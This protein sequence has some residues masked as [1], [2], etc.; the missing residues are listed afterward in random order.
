M[1]SLS[2]KR[3]QVYPYLPIRIIRQIENSVGETELKSYE[4][5]KGTIVFA[6]VAGF[7]PMS[8][9]IAKKGQIGNEEL[10]GI[11]TGY[12]SALISE[13]RKYSGSVYQFAGDSVLIAF[14][15]LPGEHE[16]ENILRTVKCVTKIQKNIKVFQEVKILEETYNILAKIGV[17]YG[18]Y[19]QLILGNKNHFFRSV[20]SGPAVESAVIAQTL[21]KGGD[22]VICNRI[23]GSLEQDL[24]QS[25]NDSFS[26]LSSEIEPAFELS[27]QEEQ[28]PDLTLE[29]F[30]RIERFVDP[31]LRQKVIQVIDGFQYDHR[32][33]TSVLIRVDANRDENQ[34]SELIQE[35]NLIYNHILNE[36]RIFGGFVIQVDFTDKGNVFFVLFNAPVA[37][38]NKEVSA[39]KMA[40]RLLQMIKEATSRSLIFR[41][42]IGI[43]TGLAFCGDL[44]APFRKG[45]TVIGEDVNLA[46]RLMHISNDWDIHVDGLTGERIKNDFL[47]EQLEDQTLKGFD[48]PVRVF[49]V[50]N[51]V[52]RLDG[53]L[54]QYTNEFVGRKVEIEKLVN[55]IERMKSNYGQICSVVGENGI[56]KS[57]LLSMVMDAPVM[58]GVDSYPGFCTPQQRHTPYYPWK[59]IL[60]LLLGV[61]DYQEE[62]FRINRIREIVIEKLNYSLKWA[63]LIID[64]LD[65]SSVSLEE[66]EKLDAR[67]KNSVLFD[68]IYKLLSRKSIESPILLILE[69]THWIDEISLDLVK[70][71]AERME[72]LPIM[73]VL[74]HRPSNL[75]NKIRYYNHYNLIE[76]TQVREVEMWGYLDSLLG[77]SS[78]SN[79][80]KET[81]I[82]KAGGNPLFMELLIQDM[83]TRRILK[84]NESGVLEQV[85]ETD[86]IQMPTGLQ[87]VILNRIDSLSAIEKVTIK[88]ASVI[89]FVFDY[90][91]LREII[92]LD[93]DQGEL[94][95]A[96]TVLE[97][98]DFI[99][100]DESESDVYQFRNIALYE[101]AYN[102]LLLATREELHFKTAEV[103]RKRMLWSRDQKVESI[104]NHY[105]HAGKKG[106]A[107][108]FLILAG[109]KAKREFD[110]KDALY[111]FE[112]ALEILD[113]S[114]QSSSSQTA[115]ILAQIA[116]IKR[117]AGEFDSALDYYLK[118]LTSEIDDPFRANIHLGIGRTYYEKGDSI[119]SKQALE[120]ALKLL[121]AKIP[122]KSPSLFFLQMYQYFTH[123]I[124]VQWRWKTRKDSR[125]LLKLQNEVMNM[126]TRVYFYERDIRIVWSVFKNI[127]ISEQL[128][129]TEQIVEAYANYA[130]Y[131]LGHGKL[132]HAKKNLYFAMKHARRVSDPVARAVVFQ[133]LGLYYFYR[134][135]LQRSIRMERRQIQMLTHVGEKWEV[136]TGYTVIGFSLMN[137][138]KFKDAYENFEIAEQLSVRSKIL[139]HEAWAS[140]WLAF[141]GFVLGKIDSEKAKK[142]M[143]R[144]RQLSKD[145]RD[146]IA[147]FQGLEC[148]IPVYENKPAEALKQ[149]MKLSSVLEKQKMIIPQLQFIWRYIARAA[150][151]Y[152]EEE[153]SRRNYQEALS[154]AKKAWKKCQRYSRTMPALQGSA[155]LYRAKYISHTKG[156]EHARSSY[157]SALTVLREG[158]NQW[159][160]ALGLE[161]VGFEFNNEQFINESLTL[162][163]EYELRADLNRLQRKL[164]KTGGVISIP[165]SS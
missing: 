20:I 134:N 86:S 60:R 111:H 105:L 70:Y 30:H 74:L 63:N 89:G 142:M 94:T 85:A 146:T 92:P 10:V 154:L 152:L 55:L 130:T 98:S 65:V 33:V 104:A 110:N 148:L 68:I 7:T 42:E 29:Q 40:F 1:K 38:E 93:M 80:L 117:N 17:A 131:L 34:R 145:S 43:T 126:L 69:D 135:K 84:R 75:I 122:G 99:V 143:K 101:V 164:S 23:A 120:V 18:D 140:Y 123:R 77:E 3:E 96:L 102:T 119:S 4:P 26:Y 64:L 48:Q 79:S 81:L 156:L 151:C 115:I 46:T 5:L 147:R 165:A 9:S 41:T 27:L 163:K 45:Y 61:P 150:W 107:V 97:S 137:Q 49:R 109:K 59:E 19:E 28:E 15:Q 73:I 91:T 121:G 14:E 31:I 95:R 11:L 160:L 2:S 113:Q 54:E 108:E 25:I 6:D 88:S 144:S 114:D 124:P 159:E 90:R 138:G 118:A 67:E 36:A 66:L 127:N 35:I 51:E 112:K 141:S 162:L 12:Y 57:R 52:S 8:A 155:E 24:S 32:E 100:R 106:Q 87:D 21:A 39:T 82:E 37:V 139:M 128:A 58:E 158:K 161:A 136:I 47:L 133:R 129:M 157:E 16:K 72:K 44:G 71:I 53:Y 50:Q 56:G 153:P 125:G 76:L 132:R 13:V 116:E 103:I 78:V 83:T 149:A 62:Q 22:A